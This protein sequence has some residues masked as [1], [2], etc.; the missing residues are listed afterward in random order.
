MGRIANYTFANCTNLKSV[1]IPRSVREIEDYTF[2][3]SALTDVYYLGTM[4][5]W[6]EN[7]VKFLDEKNTELASAVLHTAT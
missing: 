3:D 4:E 2:Y 6:N 1:T 5:Q 7:I